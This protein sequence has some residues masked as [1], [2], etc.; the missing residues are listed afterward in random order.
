MLETSSDAAVA[1]S[2]E[3]F[4]GK[5]EVAG[6]IPAGGS[7]FDR[8]EIRRKTIECRVGSFSSHPNSQ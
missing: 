5:E 1:Q 8:R 3:R 6:S 7:I 2:V 4:L